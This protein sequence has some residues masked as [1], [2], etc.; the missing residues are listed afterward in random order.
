MSYDERKPNTE[1]R[2]GYRLEAASLCLQILCAKFDN[3]SLFLF[4]YFI[5]NL[6][7]VHVCFCVWGPRCVSRLCVTSEKDKTW[8]SSCLGD[9]LLSKQKGAEAILIKTTINTVA[10]I[11]CL[12]R[13]RL[14]FAPWDT[15]TEHRKLQRFYY[16]KFNKSTKALF[17]T[18][19]GRCSNGAQAAH[20][21][22]SVCENIYQF[23]HQ[24]PVWEESVS[25]LI[26]E[27]VYSLTEPFLNVFRLTAEFL[28]C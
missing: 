25:Q 27:V 14:H 18:R 21:F 3:T 22:S 10:S 8:L 19:W 6:F 2:S 11:K 12:P 1:G 13:P 5:I 4:Q 24:L 17:S 26:W 23:V 9:R 20:F 28:V 7:Y 16:C 15:H